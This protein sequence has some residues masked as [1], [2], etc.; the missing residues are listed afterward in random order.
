MRHLRQLGSR[1]SIELPSDNLGYVGRTC[2]NLVCSRYFKIVFGTGLSGITQCICPY[3]GHRAEQSDFHTPEQIEYGK[4][5]VFR[6]MTEAVRRDF[7]AL[8]FDIKPRGMFGIGMSMKLQPA[9]P[10]PLRH[11]LERDLETHVTCINCTLR[12]A[13]Y[14]VFAFCPDCGQ[15][16]SFQ[17]LVQNIEIVNKMLDWAAK[18]ANELRGKQI[19]NALEDCV[20]S[21]DGFGRELCRVHCSKSSDPVRSAKLRFQNLVGARKAL[22]DLFGVDIAASVNADE[23]VAA[24]RA[25]QKRHLIA[26]RMGVI[27]SEYVQRSGDRHAVVGRKVHVSEAEVRQLCEIIV[28][29]ARHI[30]GAIR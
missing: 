16:N 3:C 25:F 10:V 12:Y 11:Y 5:V 7:K 8:E 18:L 14:G 4:S 6:K 13:V 26:H 1:F 29:L 23:W 27:D 20:S 24:A 9:R 22:L 2:P 15:H 21:F 19:E 30:T 17:M 28:K